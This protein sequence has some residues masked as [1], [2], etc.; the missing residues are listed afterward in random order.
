MES[1]LDLDQVAGLISRHAFAWGESGLVAGALTWRDP[2]A[3]RPCPLTEDRGRVAEPDSVGVAVRKHRQE[4]NSSSFAAV[5]GWADLEYWSG[6]ASDEPVIEAP[7]WDDW[8]DLPGIDRPLR[9][10]AVLF[11]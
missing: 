7:G 10:F 5:G 3:R 4:G 6:G 2:A 11:D 1:R 8:M 9:R